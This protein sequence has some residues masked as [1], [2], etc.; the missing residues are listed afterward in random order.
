ML[1]WGQRFFGCSVDSPD[2]HYCSP[3][4]FLFWYRPHEWVPSF[5]VSSFVLQ[6]A[7]GWT[8]TRYGRYVSLVQCTAGV[9]VILLVRQDY[10][11]LQ[12]NLSTARSFFHYCFSHAWGH[13]PWLLIS[14]RSTFPDWGNFSFNGMVGS[15]AGPCPHCILYYL[16]RLLY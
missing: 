16:S 14:T 7:I 5:L 3:W 10:G 15:G 9:T 2:T 4:G 8:F 12:F 6:C 13:L 1:D 11:A